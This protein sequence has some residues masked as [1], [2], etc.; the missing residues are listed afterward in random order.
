MLSKLTTRQ[1]PT[2]KSLC[3]VENHAF[4]L[5]PTKQY[6][7][8]FY[9]SEFYSQTAKIPYIKVFSHLLFYVVTSIRTSQREASR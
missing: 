6:F 1:A 5:V 3:H 9:T 8:D 7:H 4:G 2:S